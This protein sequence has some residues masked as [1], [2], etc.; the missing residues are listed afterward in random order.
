LPIWHWKEI[1]KALAC[2]RTPAPP[3]IHNLTR[4]SELVG[5]R[6][7]TRQTR[8]LAAMNQFNLEGRYPESYTPQLSPEKA[9]EYLARSEEV[10]TWL[11]QQ[12]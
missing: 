11:T 3:K 8:A 10:L 7:D 1:L 5:L 12:L 9:A 6:L 4:L 2:R